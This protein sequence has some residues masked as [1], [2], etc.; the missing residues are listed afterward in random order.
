[1]EAKTTETAIKHFDDEVSETEPTETE[2]T[3]SET[4][5]LVDDGLEEAALYGGYYEGWETCNL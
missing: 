4:L 5:D 3:E 2:L 1:M